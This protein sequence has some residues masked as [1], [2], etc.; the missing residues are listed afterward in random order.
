MNQFLGSLLAICALVLAHPANAAAPF[1]GKV[2]LFEANQ[3]GYALYRI[4]G[5]VTTKRGT[6]LAYCE[7]RKSDKGDWGTIDILLRRSTNRTRRRPA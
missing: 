4:P 2:D 6:V 5:I 1:I 3:D 7:A